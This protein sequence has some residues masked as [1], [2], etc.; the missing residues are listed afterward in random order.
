MM[1]IGQLIAR[2]VAFYWRTNLAVALGVGAA[3]AVLAGALLVGDSVRGSLRDLAVGRLGRVDLAV[4]SA[5]YVREAL[6]AEIAADPAFSQSF[7]GVAP[8]VIGDAIVSTEGASGRIGRVQLY[9]VD[10]RFWS[11]HG[12]TD[13]SGPSDATAYISAALGD[14]LRAAPGD[15]ILVRVAR[16]SDIP[17]ESLHARKDQ[18][19]ES[20]R[21]RV[22]DV[23]SPERLGEF[24]LG[25]SQGDVR[26]VFVPLARLQHALDIGT[27]VNGLLVS[28]GPEAA[29][30]RRVALATIVDRHAALE[31]LGLAVK[32]LDV[33]GALSIE[34]DAG[35]IDP[36]R[37]AVLDRA[38]DGIDVR[39]EPVLTYLANAIR[40]GGREVPYSLVTAIDL[41]GVAPAVAASRGSGPPPIVLGSWA[42]RD[43]AA[44][45]GDAVTLEY[46]VWE[47]PGRLVARRAP[48][49]VAAIVPT[50]VRDRDLSPVYPGITDSPTLDDWSPP[51]P[52]DLGRVRPA[53]E[54]YWRT[55]RTTPKA[56]IPIE[57]G[58]QLW[59][60][61]HGNRTSVR[62]W[63]GVAPAARDPAALR[64]LG[65][66]VAVRLQAALD[67]GSAGIDV[68][69]VRA[70]ALDASVGVTDFG[71][72]F[73][74]FSFFLV[75]S[76]L[77]LAALFFKLG[78]EQRAREIGLLR[79]VGLTPALV[80]WAFLA[81]AALVSLAG[82]IVGAAGALGYAAAI[83]MLLRTRWLGAVGTTALTLHVTPISL[84][85]GMAGGV[86]AAL[87]ITRWALRRLGAVSERNLLAGNIAGSTAGVPGTPAERRRL[88][89]IV[90]VAALFA[91]ALAG[92]A[93]AGLISQ[94]SAFFGAGT[95]VLA[96]GL[97]FAGA[98]YRR[99]IRRVIAAR[100]WLSVP[101]LG[102][103]ALSFRP[104]RSVLSVSVIAAATFILVAVDAFRKDGAA[105]S[106]PQSGLG[107]YNLIAEALFPIV[108]DLSSLDGRQVL[109]LELDP[110]AVS[111]I[112][113]LR[114]RPGDDASCLNLYR[115]Q[116]PRIVGVSERF[117]R[118][119]RFAFAKSIAATDAE[120]QNP[121]LLLERRW[122]D[123]VVPV[124]ADAN[125]MTYVL[126]KTLGEDVTIETG[127]GSVRL[128]IVA[129]LAD[130]IFQRELVM[131]QES[132]QRLF[133]DE[134][135]YRAW[136]V[137]TAPGGEA[138]AA[139][140]FEDTLRDFGVEV[141]STAE[142]LASFHAVENTYLS[143]FQTL[144]GLGLLL[145]TIGMTAVLLRNV[146]E[147]RR[148][149]ALLA[150]VGFRRVHVLAM[151]LAESGSIVGAGLVLGGVAAAVAIGPALLERGGRWPIST[152]GALL[153]AL[154]AGVAVFA[155]IMAARAA[156][157]RPLLESL[158]S[159]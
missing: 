3:V 110:A 64:S 113:P 136:L 30:D 98:W 91:A 154:V 78:V 35:L 19:A 83:V 152:M 156:T 75:V 40:I 26:A 143:T 36:A 25:A 22:T 74:Y 134:P 88:H 68:R 158:K 50:D 41:N 115:P 48:F 76:A 51:F 149:L 47:D 61:R 133:P 53:D 73:V 56:F 32:G 4:V 97:A 85:A 8:L 142:R 69:D 10:D 109:D 52:I 6:A 118:D 16:P 34:S 12:R 93:T 108:D 2:S 99:P 150:A 86:L 18:P 87:L 5:G 126:H 103:R 140:R 54:E 33:R 114:V 1:T 23:L 20:L 65:R 102:V 49:V 135:G 111:R 155:T 106:G 151:L 107:G 120:R 84:A 89:A 7:D 145:G 79:A 63:P 132:F 55:Y 29:T 14:A 146:L 81:E 100:G 77:V 119:G 58:E 15:V 24:S 94:T 159:E 72:Y 57:A 59:G 21:L 95:A 60:S 62:I 39:A 147:R 104:G 70:D 127:G 138:E 80:G 130:S 71:E 117:R 44:R 148:E 96:G 27:R 46:F 144:G 105:D 38:L 37:A 125:S 101:A 82:A 157:S 42:A 92:A 67:P 141:V 9:G 17:L 123:D 153:L 13:V 129:A 137:A 66:D 31:D 28:A 11:F 45:V 121:W 139:S 124:I 112:E 90:I 122:E 128:R 131:A 116:N 43:L